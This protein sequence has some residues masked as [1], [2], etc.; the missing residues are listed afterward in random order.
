[1]MA[2]SSLTGL[3]AS[4]G[5]AIGSAALAQPLERQVTAAGGDLAGVV[6]LQ[7]AIEIAV[8]ALRALAE[9]SAPDSAAILDF[10]IEMLLDT[11]IVDMACERMQQG[12]DAACAW[13]RA[14]DAYIAGFEQADDEATRARAVDVIDIKN[15]VLDAMLGR[16]AGSFPAGTIYVG[17]DIEPSLFLSHDWS[18]G[19]GIV[20]SAGSTVSHVAMLARARAVPMVVGIGPLSLSSGQTLLVDGA[21]G[22]VI[23]DPSEA[24]LTA[25]QAVAPMAS[26]AANLADHGQVRTANGIAVRVSINVNDPAELD[27]VDPA[28]AA[29]IGLLRTEFLLK[30][31]ADIFN[32]EQQFLTYRR[33]LGW[34]GAETVIIRLFDLG[35]DKPLPDIAGEHGSFLGLRGIRL[36]LER[37]DILRMQVRALLRAAPYGQLRI[38]LPMVTVPA[39]LAATADIVAEEAALLAARGIA[40]AVPPL[41]MMVEV[42]AAA[43]TLDL[44]AD[45]GFFS[46]GTNDL[47]QYL[48]AA[49]R[50]NPAVAGLHPQVQPAVLRL[51]SSAMRDIALLGKPASICGDMA[52]DPDCLAELLAAGLRH[53]SVAPGRLAAVK[54]AIAA[55][56]GGHIMVT[57]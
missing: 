26:T 15:R 42:P 55:Y 28:T 31:P 46:F 11:A 35:G 3:G 51:L 36:L 54:A 30:T 4:A 21:S 5:L 24:D 22:R 48:A 13:I 27:H 2:R 16:P 23:V 39:E 12:E 29:G 49:S 33:I 45:A 38:M 41:G 19:G 53:F 9:R 20:L 52:G 57:D 32:E 56:A 44:F 25:P 43:L 50:D 8:T 37:L 47:S 17:R 6:A 18:A 1:M 14:M 10:Q 34:A 40:H 7:T